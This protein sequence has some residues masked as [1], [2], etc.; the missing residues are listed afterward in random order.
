MGGHDRLS[1]L[2][3][4][5]ETRQPPTVCVTSQPAAQPARLGLHEQEVLDLM[6]WHNDVSP[7]ATTSPGQPVS[8][9]AVDLAVVDLNTAVDVGIALTLLEMMPPRH[10][11]V[12]INTTATK[13]FVLAMLGV[14]P[15]YAGKLGVVS[16]EGKAVQLTAHVVSRGALGDFGKPEHPWPLDQLLS[17]QVKRAG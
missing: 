4:A 7:A 8:N 17:P 10:S 15:F 3:F 5:P 9:M 12:R 13:Q 6:K 16:S 11:D 1:A 2:N 14:P